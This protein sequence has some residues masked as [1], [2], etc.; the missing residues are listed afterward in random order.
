M[1]GNKAASSHD[2]TKAD[3]INETACSEGSEA[4]GDVAYRE[5]PERVEDAFPPLS[6]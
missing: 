4:K 3:K 6:V 1:Q 2:R 5:T